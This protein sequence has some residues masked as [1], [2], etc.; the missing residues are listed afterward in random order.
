[1]IVAHAYAHIAAKHYIGKRIK[2]ETVG[3][4]IYE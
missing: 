1:M 4:N 2:Y 3:I